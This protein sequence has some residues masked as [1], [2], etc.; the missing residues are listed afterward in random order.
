MEGSPLNLPHIN[1][2]LCG[3][4]FLY[5]GPKYPLHLLTCHGVVENSHRDYMVRASEYLMAHGELP[6]I[7]N[8]EDIAAMNCDMTMTITVLML[9]RVRMT[10]LVTIEFA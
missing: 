7:Q 3:G 6:E 2:L 10:M 1:C 9:V 8:N 5:P 4:L